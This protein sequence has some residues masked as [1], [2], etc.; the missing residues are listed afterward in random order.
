MDKPK[1][2]A[3]VRP[4]NQVDEVDCV[5]NWEMF[6]CH[7]CHGSGEIVDTYPDSES[8]GEESDCDECDGTGTVALMKNCFNT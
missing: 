1:L 4:V 5:L 2:R 3:V 8:Y 6:E 7:H